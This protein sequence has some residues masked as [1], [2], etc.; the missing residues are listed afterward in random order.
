MGFGAMVRFAGF[1]YAG[2]IFFVKSII[3][4]YEW[5]LQQLQLTLFF[6]H[7]VMRH[8]TMRDCVNLAHRGLVLMD[9]F[10]QMTSVMN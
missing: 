6:L 4:Y 10:A 8:A 7:Q 2:G 3:L 1:Q 9:Y 5:L